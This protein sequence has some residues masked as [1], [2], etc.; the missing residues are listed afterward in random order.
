MLDAAQAAAHRIQDVLHGLVALQVDEVRREVV[1]WCVP[2]RRGGRETFA[3]GRSDDLEPVGPVP[4][5]T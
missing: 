5:G 3:G 1:R 4:S 2:V